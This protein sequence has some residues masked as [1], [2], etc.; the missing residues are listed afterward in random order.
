MA[1]LRIADMPPIK[2]KYLYQPNAIVSTRQET[3]LLFN[4]PKSLYIPMESSQLGEQGVLLLDLVSQAEQ[5]RNP[6]NIPSS[7]PPSANYLNQR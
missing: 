6:D 2:I 4:N 1:C 7:I 3:L 5:K